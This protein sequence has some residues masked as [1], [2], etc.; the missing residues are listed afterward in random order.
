MDTKSTITLFNRAHSQLQNTIFQHSNSHQQLR[1]FT[2]NEQEPAYHTHKKTAVV[3]VT[4]CFTAAVTALLLGKCR[5]RSNFCCACPIT[6]HLCKK[7]VPFLL[8]SS[9]QVLEDCNEVFLEPS[10]PQAK[11]SQLPRPFIMGEVLQP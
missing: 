10:L 11:R 8:V 7:S 3:E 2:S 5:P 9:C 1:I 6:I 4:H